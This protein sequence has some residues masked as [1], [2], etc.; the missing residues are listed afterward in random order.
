[1]NCA[2]M[3]YALEGHYQHYIRV[4]TR[5]QQS[6]LPPNQLCAAPRTVAPCADDLLIPS[7]HSLC[8]SLITHQPAPRGGTQSMGRCH[9]WTAKRAPGE[10]VCIARVVVRTHVVSVLA[11]LRIAVPG[12]VIR[13]KTPLANR[14]CACVQEVKISFHTHHAQ[15]QVCALLFVHTVCRCAGGVIT[16]S[17][18]PN[19]TLCPPG[20]TTIGMRSTSARSC[21][22]RAVF[23]ALSDTGQSS[24]CQHLVQVMWLTTPPDDI[25]VC[26]ALVPAL[27]VCAFLQ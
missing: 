8:R 24:P 19:A 6:R 26:L 9:A 25:A 3:P 21:G 2:C 18:A 20:M 4:H 14:L 12:E 1:M 16:D 17:T 10:L 23:C 13:S 11:R 7:Q 27:L 15:C 22:K 5:Y